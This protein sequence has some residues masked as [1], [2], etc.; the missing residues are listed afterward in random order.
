MVYTITLKNG[1]NATNFSTA[2]DLVITDSLDSHLTYQSASPTPDSVASAPG[3][4]T[5]LTWTAASLAPNTT[6]VAYVTATLPATFTAN[7]PYSNTV[8]PSYTTQ[9]GTQPD[10]ATFTDVIVRPV[11]A[12][13]VATKRAN[14]TANVRIGDAV[15]Y[16]VQFTV[17]ANAGMWSPIFTD[18]LP[19]GFRYRAGTFDLTGGATLNG[20]V[21]TSTSGSKEQIVWKLMDMPPGASAQIFTVIYTADV[22]GLNTSGAIVYPPTTGP[23]QCR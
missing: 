20:A 19:D 18:T 12:A 13:V 17:P 22:T 14:P 11:S 15:A 21:V 7:A 2:Y 3:Q 23:V 4:N 8:Y 9:P 16:T 5:V 10:E 6:W 1:N